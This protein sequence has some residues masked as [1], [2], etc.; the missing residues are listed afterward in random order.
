LQPLSIP[1]QNGLRFFLVPL[2][3]APTVSLAVNL[4]FPA[5]LRAYPVPH[6]FQS[7]ADP[8]S[9]PA[10]RCPRW[11]SFKESYLTAYHFGSSLSAHLACHVLRR[12]MKVHVCWSYPLIPS[13]SPPQCWQISLPLAGWRTEINRRLH[14]PQSSTPSCYRLRMSG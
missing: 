5:A 13:T 11:P 10:A 14:C 2:P 3:A 1:L 7:E 9:S 4:P 6:L 8:F 12:L